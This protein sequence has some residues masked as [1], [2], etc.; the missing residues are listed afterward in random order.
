[1]D[2]PFT[3]AEFLL[4]TVWVIAVA[5]YFAKIAPNDLDIEDYKE[6]TGLS[7]WSWLAIFLFVA[8]IPPTWFI[9]NYLR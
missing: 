3:D 9:S 2:S 1:M 6:S 8:I 5:R 7:F 4:F